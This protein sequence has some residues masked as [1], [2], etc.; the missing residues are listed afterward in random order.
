MFFRISE[1]SADL[2][3]PG[4]DGRTSSWLMKSTKAIIFWWWGALSLLL[5]EEHKS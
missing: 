5:R 3:P 4:M 2:F 1:N